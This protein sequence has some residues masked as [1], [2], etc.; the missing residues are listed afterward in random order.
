MSPTDRVEKK[1]DWDPVLH[2]WTLVKLASLNSDMRSRGS[3]PPADELTH[4]QGE[5]REAVTI[6]EYQKFSL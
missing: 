3:D 5:K 4:L 1:G 2:A 6:Q